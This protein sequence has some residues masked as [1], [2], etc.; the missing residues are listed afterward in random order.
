[1]NASRAALTGFT[2][3]H[4]PLRHDCSVSA[5]LARKPID[6]MAGSLR[7]AA[8][9]RRQIASS[10]LLVLEEIGGAYG[11]GCEGIT[12]RFVSGFWYLHA[13]GVV[14]EGGWHRMHR[15]DVAGFSGVGSS[16]HYQLLGQA[17]W[18]NGSALLTPH[19]DYFS[20]VLH[21]M[22]VGRVVLA[23]SATSEPPSA[24]NATFIHA[25]CGA[26]AD[27][28]RGGGLGGLVLLFGNPT[29]LPFTLLVGGAAAPARVEFVLESSA[30]GSPA[31]IQGDEVFLN[32]VLM[33]V[34]AVTGALPSWPIRGRA[35]SAGGAPLAL[36]PYSYGF[37]AF[38]SLAPPACAAA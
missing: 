21:G 2:A 19:P 25:W 17:G 31:A 35:V 30:N 8:S 13:L 6:E 27:A 34:D 37:V 32:G 5:F 9:D 7:Q 36:P 11:G 38:P 3:H 12:D 22:L 14:A 16:S 20:S 1:M 4:Y 23:V 26:S 24:A 10:A 29:P 33:T 28:G 18:T 15:Q